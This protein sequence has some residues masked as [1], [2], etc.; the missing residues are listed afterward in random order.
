MTYRLLF[1]PN[2][3]KQLARI[4]RQFAEKLAQAMREL[5]ASPRPPQAKPLGQNAYRLRVGEYRI[6]YVVFDEEQIVSVGKVARRSEKTYRDLAV[7]I[8]AAQRN[9]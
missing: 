2:V 9:L 6:V 7:I 8:R 3:E 4:P 1:H 5:Q